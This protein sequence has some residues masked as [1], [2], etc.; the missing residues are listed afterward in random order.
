MKY[1][2]IDLDRKKRN[3]AGA[4]AP[5]DISTLCQ[6]RGMTR[7]PMP[8]LPSE[9][10]KLYKKL[11]LMV[12][13][14]RYWQKLERTVEPNS[15]IVF[16]HPMYGNRLTKVFIPRIQKK[17]NCKFIAVIHDLESLRRGISGVVS[18]SQKTSEIADNDLLKEFDAVICH[19]ERMKEYMISRGFD[20]KKLVSLEIFDYLSDAE[21]TQP[22]KSAK[23]SIAIAGNLAIGKCAYIYEMFGKDG[24]K[25][26]ELTVHL[27]GNNY[28]EAKADP[29]LQYHGSF[30]PE[31]L[32]ASLVGDFGLVWDGISAESCAGNTGEYLK[33]NNPHK[34]SLYLSSC[35]PV[36]VWSKAAIADFVVKNGV[37]IAVD[38]LYELSDR[39][40]AISE[41]DYRRMCENTRAVSKKL[42]EGYYFNQAYQAC[43]DIIETE[44]I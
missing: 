15:V 1:Y 37:G 10:S 12:T 38:S 6:Q 27:Y 20:P 3:T 43:L 2:Y 4:K 18:Q 25:N 11:W 16:Q 30:P 34:T 8:M 26:P 36:V 41:A 21:R 5:Q 29:R 35:M 39:I 19:N 22:Q 23:P 44:R 31:E 42:K 28:E 32:P 40:S 17:K 24:S 14:P 13:A 9:K 7:F 33:Y